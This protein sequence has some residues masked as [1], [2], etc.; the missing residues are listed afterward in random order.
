MS[1]ATFPFPASPPVFDLASFTGI[2]VLVTRDPSEMLVFIQEHFSQHDFV[3]FDIEFQENLPVNRTVA[4]VPV[5][6]ATTDIVS[7]QF[8]VNKCVL[9]GL[10]DGNSKGSCFCVYLER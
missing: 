7:M 10:I 9:I 4:G 3:A 8:C 1:I 5:P 6:M 2:T